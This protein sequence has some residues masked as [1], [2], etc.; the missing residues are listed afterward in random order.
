MKQK[1]ITIRWEKDDGV[2]KTTKI[3]KSQIIDAL[4]GLVYGFPTNNKYAKRLITI[5]EEAD[6][7]VYID[8]SKR[9]INYIKDLRCGTKLEIPAEEVVVWEILKAYCKEYQEF[10]NI[11]LEWVYN[12]ERQSTVLPRKDVRAFFEGL[13]LAFPE[14]CVIST[15]MSEILP[16]V[17]G[18]EINWDYTGETN[19]I[20]YW[21][22][23]GKEIIGGIP[24]NYS[25]KLVWKQLRKWC[26][27]E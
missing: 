7:V 2:V 25:H 16:I 10:K 23:D 15:Q 19:H 5:I 27:I 11:T 8:F 14:D 3:Q 18:L 12:K 6:E 1:R 26:G 24:A 17:E 13:M 20:Y 22:G 21:I 9:E 4:R